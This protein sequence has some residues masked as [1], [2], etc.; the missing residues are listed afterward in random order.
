MSTPA[1]LTAAL[2]YHA[3][4]LSVIPLHTPTAEGCSC[5]DPDCSTAAG[6]HPRGIE[7]KEFQARRATEAEIRAWWRR[8]PTTNVGLVTGVISRLAVLDIDPRNGGIDTLHDLDAGAV[9]P[10]DNTLAETGSRGLHHY[11]AL[12]AP[13]AKGAPFQGIELQA[14]GA[15][16]V[17]PPSLHHSG[18][19]Y[20]WCRIR[21]P[22]SCG[23][24]TARGRRC[25]R[26]CASAA[27]AH[28]A[29]PGASTPAASSRT[30]TPTTSSAR[31]LHAASTSRAIAAAGCTASAVPGL[32]RTPAIPRPSWSSPARPRPQDGASAACT[33]TAPSAPSAS[34][35]TSSA[36]R[37]EEPHERHAL[38][39]DAR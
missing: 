25:P 36:C 24:S 21:S 16:V 28:R 27:H 31:S 15:L 11:F 9:M 22:A 30:R 8:W 6:K 38:E 35:S 26:G 33:P 7:W 14:D 10:D 23:I 17:A 13:L 29:A 12:D 4:D 2:D 3:R 5:Q 18:R 20:R 19:R 32:T 39:A 34:C 1:C 37:A